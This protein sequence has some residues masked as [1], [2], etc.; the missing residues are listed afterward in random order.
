MSAHRPALV[1]VA[2]A[3]RNGVIG[4]EGRL[5]WHLPA[6]LKHFQRLTMGK[7]LLMG[8][9]TF[10]SLPSTLPGRRLWVVSSRPRSAAHAR[11]FG[12]VDEA[13]EAAAREGLGELYVIGGE[14]LFRQLLPAAQRMWL[15]RILADVEG[16]TFFPSYDERQ[17]RLVFE[18]Y[19]PADARNRWPFLIQ[20]WDRLA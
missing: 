4:R 13:L 9:K 15:T 7:T 12:S 16:D 20:R 6:E 18:Q 8:R 3:A 17:W 19:R 14:Q 10:E 5:P 11:L 1:I 2:A